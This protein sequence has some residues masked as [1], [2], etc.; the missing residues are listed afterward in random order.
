[1]LDEIAYLILYI[2]IFVQLFFA[3][4]IFSRILFHN[5]NNAPSKTITGISVIIAC[6]NEEEN[7]PK[8]LDVL[9]N[10][11][12]P[13]FEV[14]IAN[15]RSTDQSKT[16]LEEACLLDNR[17]KFI[18][19]EETLSGIHP[20]K[21]A[22]SQ[23][24]AQAQ[25]ETLLFTDADCLPG[26]NWILEIAESYSPNTEIVLGYSPYQKTDSLKINSLL[27]LFIR[28]ET[29]YTGIQYL[30]FALTGM[31]YMAVGR[32]LSYKKSVFE[33]NG[34]YGKHK[35]VS[36][37]DD[38]LFVNQQATRTNTNIV[39]N[40]ESQV[41]SVPETT[42]KGWFW[43]KTRHLSVGKH[44]KNRD[45]ALLGILNL[46][47]ICFYLALGHLWLTQAESLVLFKFYTLRFIPLCFVFG[48]IKK[49][50]SDN[51]NIYL[52]PV[53]DFLYLCYYIVIGVA[54]I[55]IKRIKWK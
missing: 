39:I 11:S 55:F 29:F 1:M 23:A 41:I 25:F 42:W 40:K 20:K 16:L 51:F 10:Q 22:L 19:I 34:G 27:N 26:E 7:L 38:D 54:S 24:T 13:S 2:S 18:N 35:Q 47:H 43:Q 46:S 5:K 45:I 15:D 14:I 49:K 36:G 32:N 31:P 17:F 33:R 37:G 50:L 6:R 44:Y 9:R 53:T 21:Y 52:F 28:H 48:L 30:S 3:L 8:L 12:Y 4:F